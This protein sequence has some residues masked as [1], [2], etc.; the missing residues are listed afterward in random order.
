MP[1]CVLSNIK[2]DHFRRNWFLRK[3]YWREHNRNEKAVY[4]HKYSRNSTTYGPLP[5]SLSMM[6]STVADNDLCRY[7][8][9]TS[10][11]TRYY[12][13]IYK[14]SS[15]RTVFIK[16]W[17]KSGRANNNDLWTKGYLGA[18]ICSMKG[19]IKFFQIVFPWM[20]QNHGKWYLF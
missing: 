9:T 7:P 8:L 16:Y 6:N 15:M 18:N 17:W 1:L 12:N 11:V 20:F 4:V 10:T 3:I 2:D 13:G 5:F 14:I 19:L